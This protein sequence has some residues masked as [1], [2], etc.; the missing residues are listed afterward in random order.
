MGAMLGMNNHRTKINEKIKILKIAKK[1]KIKEDMFYISDM[2]NSLLNSRI[3]R[4]WSTSQS[5]K[6]WEDI[7]NSVRLMRKLTKEKVFLNSSSENVRK[8]MNLP[9]EAEGKKIVFLD[10]DETLIHTKVKKEIGDH[11]SFVFQH[12]LEI[13]QPDSANSK[14]KVLVNLC[15]RPYAEQLL[16]FLVDHGSLYP[17]I[18]TASPYEYASKILQILLPREKTACSGDSKLIASDSSSNNTPNSTSSVLDTRKYRT[19][20]GKCFLLC[21]EDCIPT[22]YDSVFVKNLNIFKGV[23]LDNCLIVD[24]SMYCYSKE[25][26]N[27]MKI[28]SWFGKEREDEEL[29]KL[30]EE[31]VN[32]SKGVDILKHQRKMLEI[33]MTNQES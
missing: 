9:S 18:Y 11:G 1:Y 21:R 17:V 30:Q 31:L 23:N 12:S 20:D 29:R 27:G 4:G 22:E 10:L 13:H 25:M 2:L 26:K 28:K 15:I 5:E 19:L 8:K 32:W 16:N 24:N 7:W 6:E 33:L 14:Y 3:V